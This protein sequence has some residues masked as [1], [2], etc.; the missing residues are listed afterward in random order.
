MLSDGHAQDL[1]SGVLCY[2]PAVRSPQSLAL[3]SLAALAFG[4]T[5]CSQAPIPEASPK[6][7]AATKTGP[8]QADAAS[9]ATESNAEVPKGRGKARP[10]MEYSASGLPM[11]PAPPIPKAPT[12]EELKM[13]ELDR[14]T[15][16]PE[17]RRQVASI[18]YRKVMQDP[19]SPAAQQL[20]I[21]QAAM[22]KAGPPPNSTD[23]PNAA[24]NTGLVIEAPNIKYP[25]P[26]DDP[27]TKHMT[28][29]KSD[30]KS[31]KKPAQDGG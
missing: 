2:L 29:M 30:K 1:Q 21:A 16:T 27:K 9:T 10:Q 5:A 3:S 8:S 28:D 25:R 11:M 7:Q 18:R 15:L 22:L 6:A 20:R 14:A 26:G 24:D 23:M 12:Q 31:D 17:Q 4:C 19:N 13:L